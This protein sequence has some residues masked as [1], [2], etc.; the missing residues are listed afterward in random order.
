MHKISRV[1]LALL[2]CGG[3]AANHI[4]SASAQ[5]AISNGITCAKP[6]STTV[7]KVK[8]ATKV[9]LCGINPALPN[10][11]VSTWTLK[12]CKTY[13]ATAKQQQAG[14]DQEAP[15]IAAMSGTDKVAATNELNK[16]QKQLD[17]VIAAIKENHCKAGL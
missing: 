9:Y 3:L 16:A 15:L 13:L 7:V 1:A 17:K 10:A 11:T 4:E 5:A 8:G 6:G 12:T 2:I 14:L